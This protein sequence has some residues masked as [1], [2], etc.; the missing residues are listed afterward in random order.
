M[1]KSL[2]TASI[3]LAAA[4]AHANN[5]VCTGKDADANK[6]LYVLSLSGNGVQENQKFPVAV[7]LVE[8]NPR[9]NVLFAA[10]VDG[11]QEDVM[12]ALKSR[13]SSKTKIQGTIFLDELY[14][15]AL[16]VDGKEIRFDCEPKE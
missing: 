11:T 2:L 10:V 8:A 3:L 12:F 15:M 5:Y 9:E 1:F 7:R 14:D 13:R 4:S 6:T 16:T